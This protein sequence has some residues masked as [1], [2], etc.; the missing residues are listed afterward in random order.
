MGS[1]RN[2]FMNTDGIITWVIDTLKSIFP[3]KNDKTPYCSRLQNK[4]LKKVMIIRAIKGFC[5]NRL[6]KYLLIPAVKKHAINDAYQGIADAILSSKPENSAPYHTYLP[7]LCN[8]Q[9]TSQIRMRSAEP[10]T[11]WMFLPIVICRI[12]KRIRIGKCRR[13]AML[14]VFCGQRGDVY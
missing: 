3:V 1:A 13:S 10:P 4:E 8:P 9:Q 2:R 12:S 11:S 5:Q 14:L 6:L 7:C